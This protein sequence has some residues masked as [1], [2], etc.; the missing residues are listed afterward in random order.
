MLRRLAFLVEKEPMLLD[1]GCTQ[2]E[3]LELLEKSAAYRGKL[4]R[5][6]VTPSTD[7]EGAKRF[8]SAKNADLLD[9]LSLLLEHVKSNQDDSGA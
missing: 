4:F 3:Y 1:M 7:F 6:F 5:Y 2:E 9:E 8:Y